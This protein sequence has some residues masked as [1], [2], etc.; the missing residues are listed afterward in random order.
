MTIEITPQQRGLIMSAIRQEVRVLREIKERMD[1]LELNCDNTNKRIEEYL[2]LMH[3][4]SK[5]KYERDS[6]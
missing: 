3:D 5:F 6:N 2:D 1:A 4:L